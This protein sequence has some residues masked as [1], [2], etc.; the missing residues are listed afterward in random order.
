MLAGL[1][2]IGVGL[3]MVLIAKPHW[4]CEVA[5]S[6][7]TYSTCR[8]SDL[9]SLTSYHL[10]WFVLGLAL[11]IMAVAVVAGAR[12]KTVESLLMSM[13]S[14]TAGPMSPSPLPPSPMAPYSGYPQ[15]P[16]YPGQ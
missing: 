9:E 11:E 16:P 14:P 10:F 5:R 7:P 13:S 8:A 3:I 12:R 2:S 1:A 6:E 15:Q 4:T